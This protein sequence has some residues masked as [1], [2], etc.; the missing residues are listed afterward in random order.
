[1]SPRRAQETENEIATRVD[2]LR[3]GRIDTQLV[4]V[5]A[6]SLPKLCSSYLDAIAP[7]PSP[8]TTL[9]SSNGILTTPSHARLYDLSH[10]SP[11]HSTSQTTC[12]L[13][14][15]CCAPSVS[16][17]FWSTVPLRAVSQFDRVRASREQGLTRPDGSSRP[18]AKPRR[19]YSRPTRLP[20]HRPARQRLTRVVGRD[21]EAQVL[22]STS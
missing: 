3:N 4:L 11:S 9:L 18:I 10:V 5:V 22:E 12:L 2:F 21:H 7:L 13:L 8:R 1:V 6:P 14:S 20:P 16:S 19:W 17:S 15:A